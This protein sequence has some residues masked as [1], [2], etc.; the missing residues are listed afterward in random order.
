MRE[1]NE[2]EDCFSVILTNNT[3]TTGGPVA[4]LHRLVTLLKHIP[5]IR[6]VMSEAKSTLWPKR[7]HQSIL[8]VFFSHY[9]CL[10]S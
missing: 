4:A 10:K 3:K 5:D 1:D 2:T 7:G 6:K 9:K 8:K